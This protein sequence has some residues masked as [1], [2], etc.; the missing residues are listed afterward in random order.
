MELLLQWLDSKEAGLKADVEPD[1]TTN[2]I[3]QTKRDWFRS[4]REW[5]QLGAFR[6]KLQLVLDG[7]VRA[8]GRFRSR[9]AQN[10][11]RGRARR[12][13]AVCMPGRAPVVRRI[14]PWQCAT[15]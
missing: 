13:L 7:G 5:S 12:R 9:F 10:R 3:R 15:A 2:E 6:N 1:E 8:L 4:K 11:G 14:G